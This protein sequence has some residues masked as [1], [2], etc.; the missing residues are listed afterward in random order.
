MGHL[1]AAGR[2]EAEEGHGEQWMWKRRCKQVCGQEQYNEWSGRVLGL[3][4]RET[5]PLSAVVFYFGSETTMDDAG[6]DCA[7]RKA[8]FPFR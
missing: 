3:K 2:R 8:S 1:H 6:E 5:L 4:G 7:V